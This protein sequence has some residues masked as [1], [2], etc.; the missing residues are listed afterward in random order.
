MTVS[1]SLC[2]LTFGPAWAML[3]ENLPIGHTNEITA[4]PTNRSRL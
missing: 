4:H 2:H 3:G 1:V